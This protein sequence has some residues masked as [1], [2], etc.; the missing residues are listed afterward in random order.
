VA[1]P[2]SPPANVDEATVLARIDKLNHGRANFKTLA[3]EL[4]LPL[5]ILARPE[6]PAVTRE[7]ACVEALWAALAPLLRRG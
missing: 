4:G 7:F 2:A 6:L 5:L 3:R 1:R